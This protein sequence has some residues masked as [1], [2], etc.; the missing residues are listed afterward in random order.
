V[1]ELLGKCGIDRREQ[2]AAIDHFVAPLLSTKP[3]PK[4]VADPQA[5]VAEIVDGIAAG[6]FETAVLDLALARARTRRS[7][8]PSLPM[9]LQLLNGI[10]CELTAERATSEA[11]GA[12]DDNAV[13]PA[14]PN[15]AAFQAQLTARVS[16]STFESWQ[17][18]KLRVERVEETKLTISVPGDGGPREIAGD[19]GRRMIIKYYQEDLEVASRATTTKSATLP[20]A[21][22]CR[23]MAQKPR[24][25]TALAHPRACDER[26]C[27]VQTRPDAIAVR[28]GAAALELLLPESGWRG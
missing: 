15:T 8:M 20:S 1:Q 23:R 3:V 9:C 10:D 4:G 17:L 2:L 7:T 25:S 6:D 11:S 26:D 19:G 21:E 12:N 28:C 27:S 5:Y 14:D 18:Y 16:E 13:Q 22:R 24:V